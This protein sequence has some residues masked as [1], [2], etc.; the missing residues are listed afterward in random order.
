MVIE[1]FCAVCRPTS[2]FAGKD[3][4]TLAVSNFTH[5]LMDTV[6]SVGYPEASLLFMPLLQNSLSV[7]EVLRL[8]SARSARYRLS[9]AVLVVACVASFATSAAAAPLKCAAETVRR[10]GGFVS[11]YLGD[12]VLVYFGYPQA[13]EDDAERAVRAGLELIAA[14]STLKNDIRRQY[15]RPVPPRG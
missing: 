2:I 5:P 11:Q 14:V 12:G 10:F 4:E 13:H 3:K 1:Q 6:K 7:Q 15:R 8:R 9:I